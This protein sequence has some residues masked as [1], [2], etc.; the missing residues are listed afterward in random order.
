LI[1]LLL[2][3]CIS[4]IPTPYRLTKELFTTSPDGFHMM[5]LNPSPAKQ[6]EDAAGGA[7]AGGAA[8]GGAAAGG[9]QKLCDYSDED[10]DY[11]EWVDISTP[12]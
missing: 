6:Q 8:A 12:C 1:Y 9:G 2:L 4:W 11:S 7:A 5:A 10:A 3:A